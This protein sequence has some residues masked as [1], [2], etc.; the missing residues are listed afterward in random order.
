[1]AEKKS[2]EKDIAKALKDIDVKEILLQV[3]DNVIVT[4]KFMINVGEAGI[5]R[6]KRAEPAFPISDLTDE[7]WG[8]KLI[9]DIPEDKLGPVL[10]LIYKIGGPPDLPSILDESSEKLM[11]KGKEYVDLG[12]KLKEL[13]EGE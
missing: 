4:G 6:G 12:T 13:L 3:A 7:L 2:K 10:K 9:E 8:R 5:K 11:E 1:M